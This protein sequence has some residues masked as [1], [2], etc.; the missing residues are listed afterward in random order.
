MPEARNLLLMVTWSKAGCCQ[1]G[2]RRCGLMVTGI[3]SN[4][5][6]INIRIKV[7]PLA[8]RRTEGYKNC[9]SANYLC[10]HHTCGCCCMYQ[11]QR[12]KVHCCWDSQGACSNLPTA[13][14]IQSKLFMLHS[15]FNSC[16]NTCMIE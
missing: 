4:I 9:P 6:L 2:L 7:M 5:R 3:Q 1:A 14:S 10:Q 12:C 11:Q 13:N 8:L 15:Q 16:K